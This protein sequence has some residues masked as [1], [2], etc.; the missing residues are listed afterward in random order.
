M[1]VTSS[2]M[3]VMLSRTAVL[4]RHVQHRRHRVGR[5]VV[6]AQE[7]QDAVVGELLDD[8]SLQITKRSPSAA[9]MRT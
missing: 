1:Q 5:I 4:E 9:S 8:P 6:L 7:V 3:I 2:T